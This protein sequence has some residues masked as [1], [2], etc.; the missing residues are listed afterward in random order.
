[1]SQPNQ[2]I[3]QIIELAGQ[4]ATPLPSETQEQANLQHLRGVL[5]AA[6]ETLLAC[7][8]VQQ[9]LEEQVTVLEEALHEQRQLRRNCLADLAG[10]RRRACASS[11]SGGYRLVWEFR[12]KDQPKDNVP[13]KTFDG[14]VLDGKNQRLTQDILNQDLKAA[15][16]MIYSKKPNRKPRSR[17]ARP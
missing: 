10:A 4:N 3:Q 5:E 6:I 9:D 2:A 14:C 12:G 11:Q 17:K 16:A 15:E 1:V 13:C 8:A 7:E